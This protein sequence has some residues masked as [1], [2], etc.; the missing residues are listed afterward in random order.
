M[1][2]IT[3]NVGTNTAH[4]GTGSDTIQVHGKAYGD[5]GDDPLV[6]ATETSTGAHDAYAGGGSGSDG[7][8]IGGVLGVIYGVIAHGGTADGGSGDDYVEVDHDNDKAYGGSGSDEVDGGTGTNKLLDCGSAYDLYDSD[9]SD[10][11]RRCEG[12]LPS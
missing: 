6:D 3:D 5:A 11:V 9:P 1:D 4:G 2:F 10:T 12:P 8:P 7:F